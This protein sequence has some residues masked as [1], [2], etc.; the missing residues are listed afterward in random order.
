MRR[1]E[2]GRRVPGQ[3]GHAQGGVV[4]DGYAVLEVAGDAADTDL[5]NVGEDGRLVEAPVVAF[6]GPAL[7]KAPLDD[8]V[9]EDVEADPG[10][11]GHRGK[12][13]VGPAPKG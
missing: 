13:V 7:D 1:L 9:V 12:A 2:A 10:V 4:V 11:L 6:L 8:V 3:E 5:K